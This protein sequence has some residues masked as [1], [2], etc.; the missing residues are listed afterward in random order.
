MALEAYKTLKLH[1]NIL[2]VAHRSVY[3][4]ISRGY[5]R[6]FLSA[7]ERNMTLKTLR[8]IIFNMRYHCL[9]NHKYL[10]SNSGYPP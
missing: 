4:Y 5:S 9:W 6:Y 10:N 1:V 8:I 7:V 2:F 3:I